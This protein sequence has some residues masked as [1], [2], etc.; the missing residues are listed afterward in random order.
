M[1]YSGLILLAFLWLWTA[2]GLAADVNIVHGSVVTDQTT[3]KHVVLVKSDDHFCSG[4]LVAKNAVLTAGHC[5]QPS[6]RVGF[7]K[8][9]QQ[10]IYYRVIK[11]VAHP[12]FAT[13]RHA[14]DIAILKLNGDAPMGWEPV[15]LSDDNSDPLNKDVTV[16]GYGLTFISSID[17]NRENYPQLR[18][19]P[20]HTVDFFETNVVDLNGKSQESLCE[21]DSGGP[22]MEEKLGHWSQV[23]VNH[24][25]G[26]G[27][28]GGSDM[29]WLFPHLDF[30][31][32][33][34]QDL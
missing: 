30:I 14:N 25:T 10:P 26:K 9:G 8:P 24:A 32:K 31:Q 28:V 2:Q 16:F 22:V 12:L 5:L 29:V 34:L 21:G 27:C 4:S 7:V 15:S 33:T 19:A 13:A 17:G 3:W 11:T 20:V 23:G 6:L 18:M 1:K